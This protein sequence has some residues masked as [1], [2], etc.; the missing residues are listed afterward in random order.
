M[1]EVA[2]SL[3]F[4]S[5]EDEEDEEEDAEEETREG[6]EKDVGL[7]IHPL[8]VST[9]AGLVFPLCSPDVEFILACADC[10]FAKTGPT[11]AP[12]SM[13]SSEE[14]LEISLSSFAVNRMR[15]P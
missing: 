1:L 10:G 5:E 12:P 3:L 13:L 14:K 8:P 6:N 2:P 15:R 7:V 9:D 4:V 11:D